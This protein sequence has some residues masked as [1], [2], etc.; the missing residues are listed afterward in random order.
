MLSADC[1]L[2]VVKHSVIRRYDHHSTHTQN[3]IQSTAFYKFFRTQ[4][5]VREKNRIIIAQLALNASSYVKF[6]C[7]L[8]REL[9][10]MECSNLLSFR[11]GYQRKNGITFLF[12]IHQILTKMVHVSLNYGLSHEFSKS[13]DQDFVFFIVNI[14]HF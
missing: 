10:T 8:S 12:S 3:K 14:S 13:F 5:E 1:A 9:L 4:P 2:M 6:D 7:V 11:V